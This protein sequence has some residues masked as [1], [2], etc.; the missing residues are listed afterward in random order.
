MCGPGPGPRPIVRETE[1]YIL[2]THR[3][4]SLSELTPPPSLLPLGAHPL[5]AI[6]RCH[7]PPATPT[8]DFSHTKQMKAFMAATLARQQF[9]VPQDDAYY[10]ELVGFMEGGEAAVSFLRLKLGGTFGS[11]TSEGFSYLQ[12]RIKERMRMMRG[13]LWR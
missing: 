2:L 1:E 11:M 4:L 12:Q 13:R 10:D 5:L 8:L 6:S 7:L 3:R 9:R